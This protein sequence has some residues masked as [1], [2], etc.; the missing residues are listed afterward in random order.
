ML[1]IPSIQAALHKLGKFHFYYSRWSPKPDVQGK[2]SAPTVLAAT[3]SEGWPVTPPVQGT[4]HCWAW[5]HPLHPP[6]VNISALITVMWP[7]RD[8]P[9]PSFCTHQLF[10]LWYTNLSSMG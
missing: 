4:E 2:R 8:H 6:R 7:T 9:Q 3:A 1:Q 10:T 5:D